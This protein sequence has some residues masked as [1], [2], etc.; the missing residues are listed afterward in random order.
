M[1][2]MKTEILIL[3]CGFLM[4]SSSCFGAIADEGLPGSF[5]FW[6]AGAR[7]QAMANAFTGLAD[8][9][10]AAYWNPAGLSFVERKELNSFYSTLYEGINYEY[11]SYVHP[12]NIEMHLYP[13]G[14]DDKVL[15]Q[16]IFVGCFGLSFVGLHSGD[17]EK[18]DQNNV[19]AGLFSSNQMALLL[20]YAQ[21][22]K[23]NFSLG[24]NIKMVYHQVDA[25]QAVGFGLD[26]GLLYKLNVFPLNIGL[27]IQNL[28]S[29]GIKL[30][31]VYEEYPLGARIGIAYRILSPLV[32]CFDLDK[33][34]DRA[35][36][37]AF[38]AEYVLNQMFVIRGGMSDNEITSGIGVRWN[39]MQ[40]DY[41]FAYNN[42]GS[43]YTSLGT[44]H[45]ISFNIYWPS[46]LTVIKKSVDL[47]YIF[48][49][50]VKDMLRI[51]EQSIKEAERNLGVPEEIGKAKALYIESQKL[52]K[53]KEYERAKHLAGE[54]EMRARYSWRY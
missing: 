12:V 23:S 10:S 16:D 2:K 45:R 6:G 51:T 9:A 36:K 27:R 38:G 24:T 15:K 7:S 20:S 18:R 34:G 41:A 26:V 46:T 8:D 5:L 43:G 30:K 19:D 54:A 17:M 29:P 31:D 53:A 47:R 52:L 4:V 21:N 1:K 32:F 49:K 40:F 3:V 33:T 11:I 25:S 35:L 22:F 28:V 42:P 48:E 37:Y 39:E 50:E 44:S 13:H 14:R